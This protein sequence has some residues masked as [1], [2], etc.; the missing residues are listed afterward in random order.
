MGGKVL[1]S[2]ELLQVTEG[3]HLRSRLTFRFRDGSIDDETTTFTQDSLFHLMTDH[4]VQKGPSFPH[5][6][7]VMIDVPNGTV[8]RKQK[9]DGKVTIDTDS[10]SMPED[11][12]NGLLLDLIKNY[13]KDAQEIKFSML[14]AASK[15]R[16]V[17]LA[18]SPEKEDTF[19]VAGAPHKAREY[20][21]KIEIGGIAGAIAHVIGEKP[22]DGHVWM[23]EGDPPTM[24]RAESQFYVDGPKWRVE[25]C[26]P[27]WR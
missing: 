21:I 25:L 1:A 3:H 6:M 23:A 15:P 26:G 7:D 17:K 12:S 14:V 19:Y 2:G 22:L 9:S 24:I 5:P 13:P 10:T 16:V 8:T 18:I 27:S 11:L 4:H 20:V